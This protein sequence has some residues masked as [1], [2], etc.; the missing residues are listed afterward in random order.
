MPL[1]KD[2]KPVNII[3]NKSL[4]QNFEISCAYRTASVNVT[5]NNILQLNQRCATINHLCHIFSFATFS[6]GCWWQNGALLRVNSSALTHRIEVIPG[7]INQP[8]GV[9][10][11][12]GLTLAGEYEISLNPSES[13][14][15]HYSATAKPFVYV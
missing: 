7:T 10:T 1:S 14:F 11:K 12:L 9:K 8:V 6:S 15:I 4:R 3:P 2:T 13:P 5:P